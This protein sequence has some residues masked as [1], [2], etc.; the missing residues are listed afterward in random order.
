MSDFNQIWLVL[1]LFSC[2]PP[3]QIWKRSCILF[4]LVQRL[5]SSSNF[6]SCDLRCGCR[7]PIIFCTAL[8]AGLCGPVGAARS[9]RRPPCCPREPWYMCVLVL[10]IV[11]RYEPGPRRHTRGRVPFVLMDRNPLGRTHGLWSAG[12]L[13]VFSSCLANWEFW[14]LWL[15]GGK[16]N[17]YS[18]AYLALTENLGVTS[19]SNK[20]SCRKI[21]SSLENDVKTH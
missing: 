8:E 11:S 20:M 1:L 19:G 14:L 9:Q 18:S 21:S 13:L 7:Q 12:Q 3:Y 15:D 5:V 2:I 10:N 17:C 16:S 6:G 4:L